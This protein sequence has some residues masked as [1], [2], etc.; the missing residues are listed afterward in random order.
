M[1]ITRFVWQ[2]YGRAAHARGVSCGFESHQI[3]RG[4]R[5]PLNTLRPNLVSVITFREIAPRT[6]KWARKTPPAILYNLREKSGPE[7]KN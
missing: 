1:T 2:L 4:A 5:V 6:Y 3:P 7:I